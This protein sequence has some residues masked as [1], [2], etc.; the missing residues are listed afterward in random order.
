M[1]ILSLNCHASLIGLT[2]QFQQIWVKWWRQHRILQ[3]HSGRVQKMPIWFFRYRFVY[4]RRRNSVIHV[5]LL[6]F[7]STFQRRSTSVHSCFQS[8]SNFRL[9]IDGIH[10]Y[11]SSPSFSEGK[12][13]SRPIL[14]QQTDNFENLAPAIL[15]PC[16]TARL[17]CCHQ[18]IFWKDRFCPNTSVNACGANFDKIF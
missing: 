16:A 1:V 8:A 13:T 7:V 14:R 17:P 5:Y 4:C 9:G 3:I 10:S 15:L 12:W 18:D 2:R 6:G 11:Q